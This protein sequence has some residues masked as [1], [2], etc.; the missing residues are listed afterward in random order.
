M[1]S[2]TKECHE[3]AE[4]VVE[5]SNR[6]V[7]KPFHYAVPANLQPLPIGSRVLVPFG[8]RS[9]PGYVVGYSQ[10]PQ[11]IVVKPVEKVLSV[12]LNADLMDLARWM[13]RKYLCTLSDSLHCVLGPA[14][15][16][17]TLPRGIQSLVSK[18]QLPTLNITKKQNTVLQ[19]AIEQPG[20]NKKQL[21]VLAKVST[22]TV[23][24]LIKKNLLLWADNNLNSN[25]YDIEDSNKRPLLTIE[26]R[27]VVNV[28]CKSIDLEVYSTYLLHGVT[29]SGKTEVYLNV[30]AHSLKKGKQS[31]VLVPEISLTPQMV[32][33]FRRR[34]GSKVAVLHSGL[35]NGERYRE[36]IRIQRGEAQVVLGARSAIFAPVA[37][38]GIIIIDEEHE[39]SYKQDESPK[40]HAREV[41]IYRARICSAMV[42]LGSATPSLESYCR[43]EPEGPYN[44]LSISSR[45]GERPLPKVHVVD[46]RREIAKGSGGIFSGVLLDKISETINNHQQVVLFLNRR[47]FSTFI[48]CRSCGEVLKCP[49]CEISLTYH[50]NGILRCHYCNYGIKAPKKCSHCAGESIDYFGTGTQRVEQE[51]IQYFPNARVLRM[52]GD[53][54]GRKGSHQEILDKFRSG[55]ADILVGTQMIA[56]GLDIPGVT[57]VGVVNADT[58]LYMPDFRAA[59]RTF[60]L[61]TQVAGRSGRGT[62]PGE[63]IIQTYNPD[64]YSITTAKQHDYLSFYNKE[65]NFRRSLC[66][67][68]FYYL[69]RIL[70]TGEDQ[71]QV[72]R[73]S[74]EIK[75]IFDNLRHDSQYQGRIVVMGPSPAALSKIQRRYRWQLV[76]KGPLAGEVHS[77]TGRALQ[78]WDQIN[79]SK[80]KVTIGADIDPQV[81]I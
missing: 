31:I 45:V 9:V 49:H 13:A 47:G 62:C 44:L 48:V 52:D 78:W 80:Q 25:K 79:R 30:I 4:I 53:T 33:I 66:Y 64:H 19:T 69:A 57:L 72:E 22:A 36:R 59:E 42:I 16:K 6:N 40:Y 71:L 18:E 24:A 55:K 70:V 7:D 61:L 29:G 81:L 51:V 17:K 38:L 68:P 67:P 1:N 41:A 5:M 60:Q 32:S 12:G 20:L 10:P 26:Q 73:A 54:T 46:M 74:R 2:L 50:H 3:Y 15:D 63:T 27:H 28:L 39:P 43:A 65:M 58:I 11:N 56:K 23:D 75:E 14:R 21:A 35:S 8:T 37:N 77:I 34:F 76:I